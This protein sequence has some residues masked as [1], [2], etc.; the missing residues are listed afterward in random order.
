MSIT[1]MHFVEASTADEALRINSNYQSPILIPESSSGSTHTWW[2]KWHTEYGWEGKRSIDIACD[3][4]FVPRYDMAQ[5]YGWSASSYRTAPDEPDGV[6]HHWVTLTQSEF[7]SLGGKTNNQYGGVAWVFPIHKFASNWHYSMHG[8]KVMLGAFYGWQQGDTADYRKCFSFD[9]RACDSIQMQIRVAMNHIIDMW[10]VDHIVSS[11]IV[12]VWDFV[13]VYHAERASLDEK[14]LWIWYNCSQNW[15]R[16]D[17][18][19]AVHDTVKADGNILIA[20]A[21]RNIWGTVDWAGRV[22]IPYERLS[23]IPAPGN[24]LITGK[25]RF[26]S[27]WRNPGAY[28]GNLGIMDLAD[29]DVDGDSIPDGGLPMEVKGSCNTPTINAKYNNEAGTVEITLGDSM[30]KDNPIVIY[31][32]RLISDTLMTGL[33]HYHGTSTRIVFPEPPWGES[34]MYG[35]VGFDQYGQASDIKYSGSGYIQPKDMGGIYR[36]TSNEDTPRVLE[37]RYNVDTSE[38]QKPVYDTVKLAG[39]DYS[40][41]FYGEGREGQ[42]KLNGVVVIDTSVFNRDMGEIVEKNIYNTLLGHP[43][44]LRKADGSRDYVAVTDVKVD[45]VRTQPWICKVSITGEKVS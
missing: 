1:W 5:E 10:S 40:S 32:V 11:T 45:Y 27:V 9:T 13:P 14:G 4:F 25:I 31:E 21:R 8:G 29:V 2:L 28:G 30:D 3:L 20:E 37:I 16:A 22:L 39:R 42:F 44:Y 26:N 12:Q 18:R 43:C 33:D 34:L 23:Q 36:F 41:V 6:N 7:T 24:H 19:Y 38:N 15:H 35:V 17:D